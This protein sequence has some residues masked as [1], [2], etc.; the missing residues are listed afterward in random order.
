MFIK[1]NTIKSLVEI[2]NNIAPE[3]LEIFGYERY[4]LENKIR[5]AGAIFIGEITTIE[6]L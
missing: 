6:L 1:T 2:A 3:H 5:N 4:K